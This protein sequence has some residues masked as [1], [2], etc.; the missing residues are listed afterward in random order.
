MKLPSREAPVVAARDV[1]I[2]YRASHATSRHLAVRGVN[3]DIAT[4]EV[5]GL[6]GESGSGKSTL[7]MAVAGRLAGGHGGGVP[8]ICGGTLTVL[9]MPVRGISRRRG[10]RLG[11]R[12]GYLA[13]DGVDQL[14]PQ[15]SVAENIGEPIYLRDRHFDQ[16]VAARAVAALLEAV[17]LPLGVLT[18]QPYELSSGQVQRVAL[19]RA[20]IL[21]P[22]FLVVDEPM[23]GVDVGARTVLMSVINELRHRR[24][25]S[26]LIVSSDLAAIAAAADRIVVLYQ[27]T[28]VGIGSMDE[29]LVNPE[30]PY[31]KGLA[32]ARDR[33]LGNA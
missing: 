13:Q 20:L 23:R 24:A 16:R 29:L 25:F 15:L 26:A 5:V 31:L 27:G 18:K 7:A 1:S 28:I 21:D 32:L 14:K 17:Q 11:L 3:L 33:G 2:E 30:H 12:V 6:I 22:W 10:D 8:R 19:A 9:G 4:G